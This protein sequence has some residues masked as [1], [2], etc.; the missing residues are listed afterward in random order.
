VDDVDRHA[1]HA[2]DG[3][4]TVRRFAL[5]HRRAR[6]RVAFGAGDA[7]LQYLLL[8]QEDELA[9]LGMHGRHR[10]ELERAL[11]AV[12]QRLV[13]AHDGVLVGHE[14]L[15]AVDAFVLHQRSHVGVHAFAP[16]GHG[17]VEAVVAG[18][19]LGP[20]APHAV[21]V[22][23]RLLRGGDDEVDDA[24]RAAG[25]A[26]GAAGEEVV[27]GGRAHERQLHVRMR[28]D[29]AGHHVAAAGIERR[30]A[31]RHVEVRADGGDLAAVAQH[32]GAEFTIGVDDGAAAD[33]KRGHRALRKEG[34]GPNTGGCNASRPASSRN[35]RPA[36]GIVRVRCPVGRLG[37]H[38]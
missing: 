14:V 21:G 6:Q 10:A 30:A 38:A 5:D 18:R 19:L 11:E 26:G 16:P 13:V 28:I 1:E 35:R 29:A 9:I 31:G 15:E 12:H 3:D 8:Q 24:R 22:H 33:Q 34:N 20:A 36:H 32:V 25:E 2:G 17:D 37:R 4:G 23:Q 7:R 27:G